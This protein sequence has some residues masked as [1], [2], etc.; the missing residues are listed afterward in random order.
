M[1]PWLNNFFKIKNEI[2]A[3]KNEKIKFFL[4]ECI[5]FRTFFFLKYFLVDKLTSA[6]KN[7]GLAIFYRKIGRKMHFDFGGPWNPG[8]MTFPKIRFVLLFLGP[9]KYFHQ[10]SSF[11]NKYWHFELRERYI[12]KYFLYSQKKNFSITVYNINLM[13]KF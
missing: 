4:R 2:G 3:W 12:F 1:T 10:K 7:F 8:N 11:P 6:K 5:F 13:F 9:N